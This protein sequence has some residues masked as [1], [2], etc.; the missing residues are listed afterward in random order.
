MEHIEL[1]DH[2]EKRLDVLDKRLD[3]LEQHDQKMKQRLDKGRY[4]VI[5]IVM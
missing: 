2:L 3:V 5:S 1:N 4:M